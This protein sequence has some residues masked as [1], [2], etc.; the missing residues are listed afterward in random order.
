MDYQDVVTDAAPDP[1][2]QPKTTLD[3]ATLTQ[4][5]AANLANIVRKV[6]AGKPLSKTEMAVM[7]AATAIT[8]NPGPATLGQISTGKKPT[9]AELEER[10][11]FVANMILADCKKHE[12][13]SAV[14][15]RWQVHWLTCD[16]YVI[17]AK[18]LLAKRAKIDADEARGIGIHALRRVIATG[19]PSEV[20][21][22][23]RNWREIFGYSAPTRVEQSHTGPGGITISGQPSAPVV[24]LILPA[25]RAAGIMDT[26]PPAITPPEP[27]KD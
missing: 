3:E 12:I 15:Y 10:L 1:V 17:R 23:E 19:K 8:P 11:E 9:V 7:E 21:S 22:A 14:R 27:K 13:R 18:E 2:P 25:G 5:K 6:K 26:E 4:I 24:H 20:V 16:R